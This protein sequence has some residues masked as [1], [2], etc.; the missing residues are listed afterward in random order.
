[1]PRDTPWFRFDCRLWLDSTRTLNVDVRGAY[2]DLL[3]LMYDLDGPVP[4]D[5][6]WVAHNLHITTRRWRKYRR[7]LIAAGLMTEKEDGLLNNHVANELNWRASRRK[8]YSENGS[9]NTGKKRE[10]WKNQNNNNNFE[11]QS[12]QQNGYNAIAEPAVDKEVELELE[13]EVFTFASLDEL[14]SQ[15][16]NVVRPRNNGVINWQGVSN[17]TLKEASTM[18]RGMNGYK[19]LLE[20]RATQSS[21]PGENDDANF[22][23]YVREK[24]NSLR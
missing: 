21:E 4:D 16:L 20:F 24:K 14:S 11:E 10:N 3:V 2:I 1:M 8:I 18:I 23:D 6:S 22:L 12:S 17:D 13:R 5:D 19:L 9:K 7:V 15:K